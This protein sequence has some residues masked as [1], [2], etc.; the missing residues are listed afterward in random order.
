MPQNLKILVKDLMVLFSK[1][2]STFFIKIG[3]IF[4]NWS[5]GGKQIFCDK[6]QQCEGVKHIFKSYN[7]I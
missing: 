3:G 1:V 6:E 7:Q 4:L 5:V 2:Q